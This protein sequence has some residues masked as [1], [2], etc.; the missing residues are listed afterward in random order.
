M[1]T[2]NG[3][4]S[5]SGTVTHH[6][7]FC[8]EFNFPPYCNHPSYAGTGVLALIIEISTGNIVGGEFNMIGTNNAYSMTFQSAPNIS[9]ATHKIRFVHDYGSFSSRDI[10]YGNSY[11]VDLVYGLPGD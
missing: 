1:S 4:W 10:S 7:V 8:I 11:K 2:N 5:I 6:C 9:S 3:P